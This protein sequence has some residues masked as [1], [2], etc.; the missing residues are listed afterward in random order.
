MVK[1]KKCDLEGV[2]GSC[3]ALV[4]GSG[5]GS[6]KGGTTE[7]SPPTADCVCVYVRSCLCVCVLF[8]CVCA[9][10]CVFQCVSLFFFVSSVS[11]YSYYQRAG[12]PQK[13]AGGPQ[14]VAREG[15][16]RPENH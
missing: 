3:P 7:E 6:S 5:K 4:R 12:K 2:M 11:Q 14:N 16:G 9:C 10:V 1:N 13:V 8:V 15:P